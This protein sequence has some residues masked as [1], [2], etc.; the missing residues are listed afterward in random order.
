MLPLR[1]KTVILGLGGN[2]K[3]SL[4]KIKE[5]LRTLESQGILCIKKVSSIYLSSAWGFESEKKFVNLVVKALTWLSPHALLVIIKY[6][7]AREG[8]KPVLKKTSYEDRVLDMDILFYE[9]FV[10]SDKFLK[11]PHPHILKRAFVMV[12]AVE[13]IPHWI[14]PVLKRS[15]RDLYASFKDQIE[16]QQIEKLEA[17]LV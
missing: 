12:P 17:T 1:F 5:V 4:E 9:D 6:F 7:E 11:I 16:S 8:K 3:K 2:H 15:L 14:H 13:I 10:I